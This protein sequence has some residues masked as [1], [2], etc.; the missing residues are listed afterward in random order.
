MNHLY[1]S[2]TKHFETS[3]ALHKRQVQHGLIKIRAAT[4]ENRSS[5]FPTRS[6][7]NWPVQLQKMAKRL[8][9]WSYVEEEL[10]FPSSENKGTD[11]LRSYCEADL[12]LCFHLCRLLVFPWG[13]KYDLWCMYL[14]NIKRNHKL[15]HSCMKCADLYHINFSHGVKN[16]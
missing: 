7:I 8:K 6:D 3:E 11:Q 5:G 2:P 12:C 16:I 4:R 10:F 15:H 13:G 9:F 14:L 1:G